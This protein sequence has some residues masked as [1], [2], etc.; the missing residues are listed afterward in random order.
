MSR[1]SLRAARTTDAGRVG[2]ILSAF[3]DDTPWMPRIHSRAQDLGFAADLIDRGWVSVALAGE[4]VAGFAARDGETVHALYISE[5][6]WG[7]GLGTMLVHQ[8]QAAEDR[9]S[10]WTFQA[11]TRA[12][13]FYAH[14]GFQEIERT[15]GAGNDE[16]LPD[17]RME[18]SRT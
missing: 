1:F 17:I 10:L 9:L 2:D 8:M 13:E 3:I 12:Q 4:Q 15:D 18:W 6:M 7:R 16:G 14:L 11:N 5:R